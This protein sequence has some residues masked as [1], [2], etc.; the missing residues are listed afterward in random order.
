[1]TAAKNAEG[2]DGWSAADANFGGYKDNSGKY[3]NGLLSL[4]SNGYLSYAE[5]QSYLF[6]QYQHGYIGSYDFNISGRGLKLGAK[7][8]EKNTVEVLGLENNYMLYSDFSNG[9]SA[10]KTA[11]VQ[12]THLFKSGNSVQ[13]NYVYNQNNFSKVTTNLVNL[14]TP[15]YTDSLQVLSFETGLSDEFLDGVNNKI[16][17]R[18]FS[19]GINYRL[20]KPKF[21]LYS[22]NYYSSP[23]YSGVRR[24]SFTMDEMLNYRIS[25]SQNLYIRYNTSNMAYSKRCADLAYTRKFALKHAPMG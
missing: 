23:Y 7:V 13:L 4:T 15:V 11:G 25:K 17:K 5:A 8:G 6:G 10:G 24:G 19:S 22:N 1:L 16:S 2:V 14:K 18:G 20:M 9:V 21:S 12:A 3:Q